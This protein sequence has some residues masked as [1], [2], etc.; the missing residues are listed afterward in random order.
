ME[1]KLDSMDRSFAEFRQAM[2]D[3]SVQ[4]RQEIDTRFRELDAKK[5]DAAD[6]ELIKRI[7]FGA[8]G[9]ILIAFV[10]GLVVIRFSLPTQVPFTAG[11]AK[12]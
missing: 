3:R 6:L 12:P 2:Q 1:S 4:Y 10:G 11:S 7:V 5:A 9:I 8:V